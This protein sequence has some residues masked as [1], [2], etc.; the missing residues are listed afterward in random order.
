MTT[1]GIAFYQSNFSTE[2]LIL[3]L[4]AIWEKRGGWSWV[5]SIKRFCLF[6]HSACKLIIF[7]KGPWPFSPL[8]A[9]RMSKESFL[10]PLTFFF[11]HHG[12]PVTSASATVG[13]CSACV[14]PR[15]RYKQLWCTVYLFFLFSL[16]SILNDRL[17]QYTYRSKI[18]IRDNYISQVRPFS[19]CGKCILGVKYKQW[20]RQWGQ[21]RFHSRAKRRK[22]R[23][24]IV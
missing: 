16:I 10:T 21:C 5:V 6:N 20:Y 4:Y 1:Y 11:V 17:V 24:R 7:F 18:W 15:R 23:E 8:F 3:K 22:T 12:S 14:L 9:D 13:S 19:G 2:P